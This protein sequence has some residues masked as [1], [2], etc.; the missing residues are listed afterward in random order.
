MLLRNDVDDRHCCIEESAC[1]FTPH[2]S[3]PP[4]RVAIENTCGCRSAQYFRA[5]VHEHNEWK[6]G[7]LASVLY[8]PFASCVGC[9]NKIHSRKHTSVPLMQVCGVAYSKTS[10]R[11][12]ETFV[13]K[14]GVKRNVWSICSSVILLLKSK[15]IKFAI[16]FFDVCCKFKTFLVGC[17]I[18]TASYNT[19]ITI[20]TKKY[21]T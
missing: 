9:W 1:S 8:M 4:C 16:H 5:N 11:W 20:T 21:W 17:Q 3:A 14:D 19:G 12:G 15:G 13:K 7:R 2:R 10:C 6:T 18:P